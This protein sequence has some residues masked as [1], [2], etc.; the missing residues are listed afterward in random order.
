[1]KKTLSSLFSLLFLS[2]IFCLCFV[3][4]RNNKQ[5]DG[6][7]FTKTGIP[8]IDKAS[9]LLQANPEKDTL[10][11]LRGVAFYKEE[12]YD[13]AMRDFQKAIS[14]DSSK[15]DYYHALADAQL[16]FKQ[17]R[18]ALKTLEIALQKKPNRI[19]TMLKLSEF[20][21]ITKQF[22]QAQ[23]TCN[24]ILA[25]DDNNAE[26]NFMLGRVAKEMT[27]TTRAVEYFQTAV[28]QD[29]EHYDSYMQLGLLWSNKNSDIA[30]RYFDN[31]LRIDSLS[32]EAMY[33]KAMFF[34]NMK[35]PNF[36]AAKKLYRKII[37]IDPQYVDAIF[38]MGIINAL[39]QKPVDAEKNFAMS[40]KIDPQ[41]AK[42]FYYKGVM[43]AARNDK[44]AAN[45]SYQNA[46]SI[47]PDFEEAK[48]ALGK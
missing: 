17:S 31:A 40:C 23:G 14:L 5:A 42:C 8:S 46:L 3:A 11:A 24:K 6:D 32:T 25:V 1:M 20:Q 29:P 16:D 22:A 44:T 34:Q 39:Q 35:T 19:P 9:V 27:D 15:I 26:A 37:A 7:L 30:L 47:D 21:L 43:E 2:G 36:E 45:T 48:K 10:W 12:M 18:E 38:N 4:C 33:G 41:C 28:E 13:K